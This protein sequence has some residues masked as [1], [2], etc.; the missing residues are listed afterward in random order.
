[1]LYLSPDI[2]ED[3]IIVSCKVMINMRIL[4]VQTKEKEL[5]EQKENKKGTPDQKTEGKTE[6]RIEVEKEPIEENKKQQLARM[7][8][9]KQHECY[10]NCVFVFFVFLFF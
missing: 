5:I 4:R 10:N 6:Q 1:M 8:A 9:T 3:R 2:R 7:T